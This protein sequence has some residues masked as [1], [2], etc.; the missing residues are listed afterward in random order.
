MWKQMI[1]VTVPL[2]GVPA[3]AALA[4]TPVHET[5]T[6]EA[7]GVVSIENMLGS[8]TVEGWD[9]G[10]VEV[11]GTL[12]KGPDRLD[13]DTDGDRTRVEVVWPEHND[14]WNHKKTE[15][16][17]LTVKVPR[18][19]EVRIEGVNLEIDVSA[20][21]GP[22]R[23]ETVNGGIQVGGSPE[24]IDVGTVNGSIH[25]TATT[26]D[27]EAETV[28]GGIVLSGV[29]GEVRASTVNGSIQIEGGG[30]GKLEVSSVS[31]DIDFTGGVTRQGSLDI[32]SHSG[33]ITLTLPGSVSANFD[34]STFSGKI[35]NDF[36]PE[37]TRKDKYAPGME[38]NFR[39]GGGDTDIEV[40]S[41]SGSVN[42]RKQ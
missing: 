28:N 22:V 7:K 10:E 15:D 35:T 39:T 4:G 12:G 31:G 18:G 1:A 27:L 38:L 14:D 6:A 9:R 5:R 17:D 8:V 34:V 13:V 26:G 30:I 3:V 37:A 32:S 33:T 25:V 19:S 41:F 23:A 20:L 24:S 40:S 2:L 36:G 11:T 29:K 16:T 42:L 21:D